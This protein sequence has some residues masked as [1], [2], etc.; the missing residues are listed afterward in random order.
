MK[1]SKKVEEDV[2]VVE[3]D[4]SVDSSRISEVSTDARGRGGQSP[5]LGARP[6]RV[7][8]LP[9]VLLPLLVFCFGLS[10]TI[11]SYGVL[12]SKRQTILSTVFESA[13][14]DLSNRFKSILRQHEDLLL[15]LRNLHHSSAEISSENFRLYTQAT[16]LAERY[17][18][19]YVVGWHPGIRN[20]NVHVFESRVR[21]EMSPK[22]REYNEYKIFPKTRNK[23]RFP[24]LY[25]AS[26][27][28]EFKAPLGIDIGALPGRKVALAQARDSG[29]LAA[30][31]TIQL[32]NITAE[33]EDAT[34]LIFIL[35]AY[36]K[37]EPVSVVQR[38]EHLRGVFTGVF[39][40]EQLVSEAG[41]GTFSGLE[42]YDLSDE[43]PEGV[44]HISTEPFYTVGDINNEYESLSSVIEVAERVWQ[45]RLYN[46]PELFA[47]RLPRSAS[48]LVLMLG[49]LVSLVSA[50]LI[51]VVL[52]SRDRAMSL[53]SSLTSELRFANDNL[54]R[55][56]R[57]LTQFAYVA[58]HDLQTPIRNVQAAISMLE[59]TLAEGDE[60]SV[61]QFIG[62]I[63]VSA[64]RME[65]L[66]TDLLLYARTDRG[67]IIKVPTDL[68][69]L[70]Q[71][72]VR[73]LSEKVEQTKATI[74]VD[75]L[76]VVVC[77]PA[78]LERLLL[79][80]FDNA[81]R[82][83]HP[84]R[85]PC[86]KLMANESPDGGVAITIQDNGLGIEQRHLS[87]VFEPFKRLHR[88]DDIEGTGLGLSICRGI[89][90]AHGGALTIE[91]EHNKGSIV[92]VFIPGV[93]AVEKAA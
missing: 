93:V 41:G 49:V 10:L 6:G 1:T 89:A 52:T 58:S 59:E 27:I 22:Q 4:V 8:L 85:A 19:L 68:N 83:R 42:I 37:A 2:S 34:G 39:R 74:D 54:H 5:N 63:N 61:K 9:R 24:L 75:V 51:H 50:L 18:A 33:G 69:K 11:Y 70:V 14:G 46:S 53:A 31:E 44:Q 15:S 76:P 48:G 66:V 56:N 13:V 3:E 72:V 80:I 84:Q 73:S 30:T 87:E 67:E 23:T 17:P 43:E 26:S 29:M 77:D 57:D 36:D 78:Q 20:E 32:A 25:A 92:T 71:R 64:N 45:F 35:A 60:V 65:N 16:S 47:A 88:H 79:N 28:D 40:V 82:Y 90:V 7:S 38:R 12:E 21:E 55:S 62:H 86:I 91:S 81:L